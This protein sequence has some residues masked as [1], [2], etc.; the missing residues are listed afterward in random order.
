MCVKG[1]ELKKKYVIKET[2]MFVT[3]S[4]TDFF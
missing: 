2:Q 4:Y 3:L 1:K